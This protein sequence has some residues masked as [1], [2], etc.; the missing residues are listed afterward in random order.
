MAVSASYFL[1]IDWNGDGGYGDTDEDVTSDLM[2][3]NIQRGFTGPMALVGTVARCT[4]VLRNNDKQ[5]SPPVTSCA[6]P[7]RKARFYMEYNGASAVLFEGYLDRIAPVPGQYRAQKAVIECV[8]AM[9]ILDN[10]DGAVAASTH[11]YP[12]NLIDSVVSHTY[13]PASTCYEPGINPIPVSCDLWSNPETLRLYATPKEEVRASDKIMDAC[14]ADWG[15]FFIDREG[16]P[17]FINRHHIVLD[18]TTAL[19]LDDDMVEM[20]YHDFAGDVYNRVE[21]TCHPRTVGEVYEVLAETIYDEG[22][23][24][25]SS[26]SKLINLP[27]KDPTNIAKEIGGR[28]L[29]TPIPGSDYIVTNDEGGE[30]DDVSTCVTLALSY[31]GN[32]ADVKLTN[33]STSTLFLQSVKL[34]GIAIRTR[35]PHTAISESASSI[36]SYLKRTLPLDIPLMSRPGDAQLLADY[37][38]QRYKDP[39]HNIYNLL[40]DANSSST[41]MEATRDLELHHRIEVSETQ[42][43]LS[44]WAGYIYHITHEIHGERNHRVRLAVHPRRSYAASPFRIGTSVI[45]SSGGPDVL[46]Y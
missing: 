37:L 28:D 3:A 6:V 12:H 33:T 5:Y 17:T 34:R 8:D 21:I 16:R 23:K 18:N 35:D 24:L 9:S 45:S 46:I 10:A 38:I 41:L 22:D 29:Q 26:A 1:N 25:K 19:T 30:G 14:K 36:S 4:L 27:F 15:R 40:I 31:F 43:G 42:T 7:R 2:S 32:R 20:G 11:I 39:H 13:T 44:S